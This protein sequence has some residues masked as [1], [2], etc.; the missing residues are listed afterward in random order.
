MGDYVDFPTEPYC[1]HYFTFKS[2]RAMKTI[3][4]GWLKVLKSPPQPK[5]NTERHL[6]PA[7]ANP[8]CRYSK[9][10][11]SINELKNKL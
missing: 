9:R 6:N 2:P 4:C 5:L 1:Y 11:F 3:K 8:Y 7:E 10:F